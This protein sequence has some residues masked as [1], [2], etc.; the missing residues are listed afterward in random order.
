MGWA[1]LV[2]IPDLIVATPKEAL[3]LFVI[4]GVMYT[5]GVPS[6]YATV[7]LIIPFGTCSF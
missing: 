5:A 4:G 6:T 1:Y 7:T 3:T 2:C